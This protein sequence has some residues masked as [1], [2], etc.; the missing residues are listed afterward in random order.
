MQPYFATRWSGALRNDGVVQGLLDVQ[1]QPTVEFSEKPINVNENAGT[2]T[3][4]LQRAEST[5]GPVSI[6]HATATGTAFDGTDCVAGTGTQAVLD[7]LALMAT[8]SMQTRR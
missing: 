3:L 2:A 4:K 8:H 6:N 7:R 1:A 5:R